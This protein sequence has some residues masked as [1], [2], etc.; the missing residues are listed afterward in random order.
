MI[1][2]IIMI[3]LILLLKESNTRMTMAVLIS[4]YSKKY[5]NGNNYTETSI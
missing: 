1:L 2:L 4:N 3:Y 5:K